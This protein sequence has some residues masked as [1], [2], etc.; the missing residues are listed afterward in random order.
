M[1]QCLRKQK[2]GSKNN[3]RKKEDGHAAGNIRTTTSRFLL[4]ISNSVPFLLHISCHLRII[5]LKT[6]HEWTVQIL[7][8]GLPRTRIG[9]PH[10]LWFVSGLLE[11]VSTITRSKPNWITAFTHALRLQI[12]MHQLLIPGFLLQSPSTC[13]RCSWYLIPHNMKLEAHMQITKRGLKFQ[14]RRKYKL[15]TVL[16]KQEK[17]RQAQINVSSASK[18]KQLSA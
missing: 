15:Y 18:E 13:L 2:E 3:L 11:S 5:W 10:L 7:W 8:T 16:H 6:Q 14:T 17:Y 12:E 1:P 4:N 9:Y